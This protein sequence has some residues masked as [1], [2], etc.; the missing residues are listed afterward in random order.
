M[1]KLYMNEPFA[2]SHELA[3]ARRLAGILSRKYGDD[4]SK[5]WLCF[6]F[7]CGGKSLDA[8]LITSDRFVIIELKAVGGD[9]DCGVSTENSQWTWR[10]SEFSESYVIATAPYANPFSQAKNYRTAVIGE[11]EHRQRGF[12]KN[13][14]VLKGNVNFAHWI[15]CCV[16]I[17]TRDAKDVAI[18]VKD[19]SFNVTRWFCCGT[20]G[21]VCDVLDR[22]HCNVSIAPKEIEK[23]I[24]RVLG[25]RCVEK[26]VEGNFVKFAPSSIQLPHMVTTDIQPSKAIV[27][28]RKRY[29]DKVSSI[30]RHPSISVKTPNDFTQPNS[31]VKDFRDIDTLLSGKPC[32]GD[33]VAHDAEQTVIAL[34]RQLGIGG[35]LKVALKAEIVHVAGVSKLVVSELHGADAVA[36]VKRACPDIG[37]FEVHGVLRFGDLIPETV[38]GE[39][40][41]RLSRGYAYYAKWNRIVYSNG[42]V[43]FIFGRDEERQKPSQVPKT[44][45]PPQYEGTMHA[46]F[47]SPRWLQLSIA[48]Q[49]EGLAPL[50]AK[51][52]QRTVLL[53]GD[54][55]KRYARTYMLRSCAEAFVVMDWA[56][57]SEQISKGI[58]ILD[59]GCGSGGTS[60]GCLYALRKHGAENLSIRIDGIDLNDE[61]MRYAADILKRYNEE[62][63]CSSEFNPIKADFSVSLVGNIGYDVVVASKSIGELTLAGGSDPYVKVVRECAGRLNHGGVLVV[64]DVPKHE[65]SVKRAFDDLKN[66]G[67]DGWCKRQSI[68]IDGGKDHEEFVCAYMTHSGVNGGTSKD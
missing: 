38:K 1:L 55:V 65:A 40:L 51:D 54:D 47:A 36:E 8:A 29:G 34:D 63:G 50:S 68:S 25:L 45:A 28:F 7:S 60:L 10:M 48:S 5:A 12:L 6:N 4:T 22:F 64:I 52:V 33:G 24:E 26:I 53:S 16:L 9:V 17:S 43:D 15:K 58:S 46:G 39:L 59:V 11:L 35:F 61:S 27:T 2:T 20:L 42:G 13:T 21:K 67:L 57:G 66:L 31:V 41:E 23:L 18:A 32:T 62:Y 3:Q 19:T 37:Q 14:T 30:D 44:V 56:L 49:A